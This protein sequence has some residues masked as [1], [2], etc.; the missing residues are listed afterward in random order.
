M[1]QPKLPT[2]NLLHK[3]ELWGVD[4]PL[5]WGREKQSFS[6]L[7]TNKQQDSLCSPIQN[8]SL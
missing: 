3:G 2:A 5:P 6:E 8:F 7:A 1:H 4:D